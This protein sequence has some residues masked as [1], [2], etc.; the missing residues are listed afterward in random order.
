MPG[1]RAIKSKRQWRFLFASGA[2]SKSKAKEMAHH[3]RS[4]K[5]LPGS[6]RAGA[7]SSRGRSRR[8]RG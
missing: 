5:S 4:Y 1:S 8:S 6:V 2:V 3:S 7:K